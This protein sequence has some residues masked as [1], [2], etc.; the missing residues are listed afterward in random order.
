MDGF[1]KEQEALSRVNRE[2]AWMHFYPEGN[3]KNK[4]RILSSS[5]EHQ[6]KKVR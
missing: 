6:L 1:T 5:L 3:G 4:P 2:T